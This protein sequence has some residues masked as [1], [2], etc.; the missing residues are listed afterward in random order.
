MLEK[1]PAAWRQDVVVHPV[2]RVVDHACHRLAMSWCVCAS[3]ALAPP[4]SRGTARSWLQRFFPAQSRCSAAV[5][6]SLRRAP[7]DR[8]VDAHRA[9]LARRA[10]RVGKLRMVAT[11]APRVRHLLARLVRKDRD[12]HEPVDAGRDARIVRARDDDERAHA[13]AVVVVRLVLL[14]AVARRHVPRQLLGRRRRRRR[15]TAAAAG[16]ALGCGRFGRRA[17]F[18][19]A[20]ARS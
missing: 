6:A 15:P 20:W 5:C 4:A 19:T 8:A 9:P 12:V 16:T 18:C 7:T 13:E 17:A 3:R 1:I 14:A 2:D 10:V 11:F